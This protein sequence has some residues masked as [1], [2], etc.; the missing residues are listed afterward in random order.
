MAADKRFVISDSVSK[1]VVL[2]EK[3]MSYVKFPSFVLAAELGGL[4]EDLLDHVVVAFIP[5]DFGLH[6]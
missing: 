3:D 5:I 6:H 1:L 4:A 2:H